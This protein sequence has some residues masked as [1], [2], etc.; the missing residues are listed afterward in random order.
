[1]NSRIKKRLFFSG[2]NGGAAFTYG[3]LSADNPSFTFDELTQIRETNWQILKGKC[4]SAKNSAGT[5]LLEGDRLEIYVPD[6][7][8]ITIEDGQSLIL[9]GGGVLSTSLVAYPLAPKEGISQQI[10]YQKYGS[11]LQVQDLTI[12]RDSIKKYETYSCV[13]KK[14]SNAK[15]IEVLGSTRPDFWDNLEV[16]K[17]IFYGWAVSTQGESNTVASWDEGAKTITLTNNISG[18]VGNDASGTYV[19][20][21]TYF[22]QEISLS[23]YNT[24]GNF[25]YVSE[26]FQYIA[27]NEAWVDEDDL[28]LTLDGVHLS[29]AENN[30][31]L[32]AG[33]AKCYATDTKF[34]RCQIG[35]TFFG[36][37][38]GNNQQ[39]HYNNLTFEDCGYV[40]AGGITDATANNRLGSGAYIHPNIAV[41]KIGVGNLFLTDNGS[42]AF[43]Q[44][45]SSGTKPIASGSTSE[46][47]VI[48]A[49]GNIEYDLFTSNS[50]PVT[51]DEYHTDENGILNAGGS[52]EIGTGEVNQLRLTSQSEPDASLDNVITLNDCQIDN[53][54]Q[55]AWSATQ[56]SKTTIN[57]VACV[58]RTKDVALLAHFIESNTAKLKELNI[59]GGSMIIG[60]DGGSVYTPFASTAGLTQ[61][62]R[63]VR[64]VNIEACNIS[65]F[66]TELIWGGLFVSEADSIDPANLD[67]FNITDSDINNYQL[68]ASTALQ[69]DHSYIYNCVRSKIAAAGLPGISLNIN[70][71]TRAASKALSILVSGS[72][73]KPDFNVGTLYD[74]LELDLEHNEYDVNGGNVKLAGI[75][76][77]RTGSGSLRKAIASN[78]LANEIIINAIGTDV[79]FQ[80]FD[81]ATNQESNIKNDYT[82]I[83]GQSCK[84]TPDTKD[85]LSTS[86]NSTVN[87][88][89]GTGNGITK[90]FKGYLASNVYPKVVGTASLAAGAISGSVD[91]DGIITGTGITRGQIDFYG[92]S[93]YVEFDV[94]PPAATP[95]VLSYDKYNGHKWTGSVTVSAL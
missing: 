17:T 44:Y 82:C 83:A 88:N 94:A 73:L 30:V 20:L 48:T 69:Y 89:I 13:L 92:P 93:Y 36:R 76:I 28:I 4:D 7:E 91:S 60:P 43:R 85:V 53:L 70:M 90:I 59:I 19:K 25:W 2:I 26:G 24:Y 47:G 29:G 31:F 50:M 61:N 22:E 38:V 49:S 86:A 87:T 41:K 67:V 8:K 27:S 79:V 56:M 16:G 1:M 54:Q 23:D 35:L 65:D 55:A 64:R 84:L 34:S 68:V 6:A 75:I 18:S 32:S 15:L 63:L 40:V 52:L 42:A 3:N 77:T 57:Y 37:S 78:M 21:G 12:D 11:S 39:L 74:V 45:S 80:K 51:I 10:F 62:S 33:A 14:S 72:Y 81:A 95:I 71:T 66:D 58:F 46:F 9:L 5:V